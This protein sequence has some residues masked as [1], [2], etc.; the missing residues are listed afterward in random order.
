MYQHVEAA[1]RGRKA[2]AA[3]AQ[4]DQR[5]RDPEHDDGEVNDES[6]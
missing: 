1:D 2:E 3:L 4:T 6:G 5:V